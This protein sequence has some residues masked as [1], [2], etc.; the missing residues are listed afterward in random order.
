M[1]K[2]KAE[3]QRVLDIPDA[4]YKAYVDAKKEEL[5][6]FHL[7]NNPL[8]KKLVPDGFTNWES[9]PIMK[10]SALQRPLEQRLS[11]GFTPKNVYINKTSG[12]SGT[13]T[14]FAKDKFCHAMIWANIMRRVGWYGIDYNHS[15]QARFYGM[16]LDFVALT[17]LRLKDWLSH[18]YRFN[19]FDFSPAAMDKMIE[20]FRSFKFDFINGYTGSIVIFAKYLRS[21]NIILKQICPTLKVCITTSEMLFDDDRKL[22]ETQLGIPVVNEY[23]AAE[24]DLMALENPDGDWLLNAETTFIEVVDENGNVLPNGQEG[25]LIV[26]SLYNKAHPLIRYEVGDIGIIDERSTAKKPI[27]KKLIGRTNDIAILPSG[28]VSPGMTFYSITKKLFDDDGNVGE[29][30]IKQT[31]TD[32]FDIEYTSQRPLTSDEIA[33]I[34]KVLWQFLE[35]GLNFAF[36][37]KE[38]TERG[39]SGKLKQF[40]SL[41]K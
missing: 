20:K 32:T 26:T 19:I 23:G 2:A 37:R 38:K 27:L 13:P 3:L 1:D 8:Y 14:V 40:T 12:S 33:Q 25:R 36:I 34:E 41:V 11:E 39:A 5:A 31:K 18:R 30:V 28:K 29:F 15:W 4:D 21:K 10:K 9:L 35:P 6:R 16:P 7:E 24:L 22:L 17:K